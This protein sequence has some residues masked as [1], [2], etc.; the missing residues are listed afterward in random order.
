MGYFTRLTN[1]GKYTF[2]LW[3]EDTGLAP[4]KWVRLFV[5]RFPQNQPQKR[6]PQKGRKPWRLSNTLDGR[7]PLRTTLKPRLKL[8]K[9]QRLLV[10]PGESTHS[11]LSERRG[12][13]SSRNHPDAAPPKR[14]AAPRSPRSR[15]SYEAQRTQRKTKK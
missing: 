5:F 6:A 4:L 14:A 8:L 2:P 7:N 10:F 9:P 13:W 15:G 1:Q 11:R 3:E 12:A